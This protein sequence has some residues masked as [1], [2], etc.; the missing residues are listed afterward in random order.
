MAAAP[1][2]YKGGNA[3]RGGDVDEECQIFCSVV[4]WPDDFSQLK[5]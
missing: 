3:S 4:R 1:A 5:I 2:E